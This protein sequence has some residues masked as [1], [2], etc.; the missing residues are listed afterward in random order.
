MKKYYFMA[1]EKGNS[2]A[3]YKL[4]LYYYKIKN[5]KLMKKYYLMAIKE[6]NDKAMYKMGMYYEYIKI[7]NKVSKHKY[8]N[9]RAAVAIGYNYNNT[10]LPLFTEYDF[11]N[12]NNF[13]NKKKKLMKKYYLMAI[14]KGN[15][16]AM[17]NLGL[18]YQVKEYDSYLMQHYYKMAIDRNHIES[19]YQ[20]GYY[21]YNNVK[22][23][24]D[25]I[26]DFYHDNNG[27]YGLIHNPHILNQTQDYLYSTNVNLQN[28]FKYLFMAIEEGS[29]KAMYT[30]G[31]Y[32]EM[33]TNYMLMKKYFLMSYKYVLINYTNNIQKINN[34]YL[35]PIYLNYTDNNYKLL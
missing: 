34:I 10:P 8:Y 2:N 18:Y 6:E 19:M 27:Q 4:G 3:M 16:K 28:M 9:H 7:D 11:N 35:K 33:I 1:I 26:L 23:Y 5:Y 15:V 13:I 21:Y 14:N 25:F 29:D 17:Y 32:Y 20:L 12:G 30:L 31:E 22:I 24:K